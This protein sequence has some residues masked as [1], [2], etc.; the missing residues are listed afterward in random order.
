MYDY[1]KVFLETQPMRDKLRTAMK[2][3]EEA[4]MQLKIKKD[5]L[6][7]VNQKIQDL[8]DLFN[9][10]VRFKEELQQKMEECEV[11]LDRAHKLTSGLSD[12]KERWTIDI[13]K[14]SARE[15]LVPG[16]SLVSAAMLAYSGP[17]VSAYRQRLE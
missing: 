11:K 6:D 9:E 10:K 8:T 3:V 16:D 13:Q 12:E 14:L 7:Q 5:A 4:Q 15:P 2:T 17:F 1:N